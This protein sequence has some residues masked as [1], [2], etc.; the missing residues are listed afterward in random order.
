MFQ[1]RFHTKGVKREPLFDTIAFCGMHKH[2][3]KGDY[4]ERRAQARAHQQERQSDSDVAGDNTVYYVL[5]CRPNKTQRT[6]AKGEYVVDFRVVHKSGHKGNW[7]PD[8]EPFKTRQQARDYVK[9]QL[10]SSL[11]EFRIRKVVT[12]A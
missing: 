6:Y 5:D 8:H 10:P 3:A 11:I 2:G 1:V 7:S 4:F 9:R 12:T